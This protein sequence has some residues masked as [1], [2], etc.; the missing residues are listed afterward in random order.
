MTLNCFWRQESKFG[1]KVHLHISISQSD[2]ISSKQERDCHSREK[3]W[4][5]TGWDAE[6]GRHRYRKSPKQI[7]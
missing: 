4:D 3:E 5:R 6:I 1:F 2:V 7:A